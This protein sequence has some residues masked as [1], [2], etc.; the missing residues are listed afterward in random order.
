MDFAIQVGLEIIAFMTV[1]GCN[2]SDGRFFIL[3]VRAFVN[4]LRHV[5]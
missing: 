4:L 5:S 1:R 3:F 2:K